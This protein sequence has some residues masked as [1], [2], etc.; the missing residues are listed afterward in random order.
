MFRYLLCLIPLL[1]QFPVSATAA[2]IEG[3]A[4]THTELN[5]VSYS[6]STSGT[7]LGNTVITQSDDLE[8]GNGISTLTSSPELAFSPIA[9][10]ETVSQTFDVRSEV[11]ILPGF[12]G[13][14]LE[15]FNQIFFSNTS[16]ASVTLVFDFLAELDVSAANGFGEPYFGTGYAAI[17]LGFAPQNS[18]NGGFD[19]FTV[20]TS[21]ELFVNTAQPG[22]LALQALFTES[23]TIDV[24]AF[25][26]IGISVQSI[27]ISSVQ[28]VVP[29]PPALWLFGT[30]LI[31]LVGF[32]KRR[33]A[34]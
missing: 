9:I 17:E 3:N 25:Q 15:G 18:D 13:G 19:D 20:L 26:T 4:F 33:K 28:A 5:F 29:V 7:L 32:S 21:E 23:F 10:G 16:G 6:G 22:P 2:L 27:A 24:A 14:R 30:A 1:L 34:D 31:G 11:D 12:S 8:F